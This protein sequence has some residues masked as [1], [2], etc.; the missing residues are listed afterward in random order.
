MERISSLER[1]TKETQIKLTLNLDGEGKTNIDVT[2]PPYNIREQ[3]YVNAFRIDNANVGGAD[4]YMI[5]NVDYKIENS[6]VNGI[7]SK[8]Y[9]IINESF[10]TKINNGDNI[11]ISGI[12]FEKETR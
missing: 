4:K 9:F 7:Y 3:D 10:L 5:R 12:R 1:N 6:I 2:V 11:V 8:T